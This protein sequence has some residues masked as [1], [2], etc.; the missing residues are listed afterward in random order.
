MAD[1]DTDNKDEEELDTSIVNSAKKL[2]LVSN[3]DKSSGD[4]FVDA[5]Y[6]SK[7]G[8]VFGPI[9]IPMFDEL[10]KE[11]ID[12]DDE[13]IWNDPEELLE[14]LINQG[15][16]RPTSNQGATFSD[17]D[18]PLPKLVRDRQDAGGV[19]TLL[20]YNDQKEDEMSSYWSISRFYYPQVTG[21]SHTDMTII[22]YLDMNPR[23]AA[24]NNQPNPNLPAWRQTGKYLLDYFTFG[25]RSG[26]LDSF[27]ETLSKKSGFRS[28]DLKGTKRAIEIEDMTYFNIN[29]AKD[30]NGQKRC[31][32]FILGQDDPFELHQWQTA[33]KLP[34]GSTAQLK[35]NMYQAIITLT[36]QFNVQVPRGTKVVN[37]AHHDA[38]I[39]LMCKRALILKTAPS[40]IKGTNRTF[41]QETRR[42]KY[43]SRNTYKG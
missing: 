43:S 42:S 37:K 17:V 7:L 20:G 36:V 33:I 18:V 11:L 14:L 16:I 23:L 32:S 5:G 31:T 9:Y 10:K 1:S 6:P 4:E 19:K 2:A 41:K 26:F 28:A 27:I 40:H 29:V 30:E 25:V 3:N 38:K 35:P 34:D 12:D 24:K 8:E 15:K 13:E 39:K 22:G 21:V